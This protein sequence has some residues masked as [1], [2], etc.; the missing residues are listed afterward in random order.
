MNDSVSQPD[1]P[2][3][4]LFSPEGVRLELAVAGP[5]PR[6]FAYGIDWLIVILLVVFLLI[7]L[8]TSLGRRFTR[9]KP[10]PK[11]SIPIP[12]LSDASPG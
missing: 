11:D 4:G 1:Q 10:P 2:I 7:A 3:H 5:A 9:P 8:F 6:I 12:S